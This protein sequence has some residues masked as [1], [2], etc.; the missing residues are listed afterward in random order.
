[1][2]TNV[3]RPGEASRQTPS[4][5]TIGIVVVGLAAAIALGFAIDLNQ[6]PDATVSGVNVS[7]G[8][9]VT[10]SWLIQYR[11]AQDAARETAFAVERCEF[12]MGL[13][14]TPAPVG[15]ES[16]A[17]TDFAV[18]RGEFLM[19]LN[20]TPGLVSQDAVTP[21]WADDYSHFQNIAR[22]KQAASQRSD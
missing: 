1:M 6:S 4:R 7:S 11:A 9:E 13:N 19:D 15:G 10:D 20:A 2:S 21:P 3:I 22:G 8:Q 14:A 12:L 17:L 16:G 18:E 5:K